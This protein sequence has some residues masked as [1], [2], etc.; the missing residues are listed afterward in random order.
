MHRGGGPCAHSPAHARIRCMQTTS[1]RTSAAN[2]ELRHSRQGSDH[3]VIVQRL[4]HPQERRRVQPA[5]IPE[6]DR[7][8]SGCGTRSRHVLRSAN[9]PI[10]AAER[11]SSEDRV[12]DHRREIGEHTEAEGKAEWTRG[13]PWHG[14]CFGS[15]CLPLR[16]HPLACFDFEGHAMRLHPP[17][18]EK[19]TDVRPGAH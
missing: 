1:V 2:C 4:H 15:A 12:S 9:S 11:Q 7:R 14:W 6:R 13:S 18:G 17:T 8:A 5:W 10:L 16:S 3:M 19:E